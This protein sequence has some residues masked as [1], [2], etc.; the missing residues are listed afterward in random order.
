MGRTFEPRTFGAGNQRAT[1]APQVRKREPAGMLGPRFF[2]IIHQD[3]VQVNLAP[4]PEATRFCFS[5]LAWRSLFL[6]FT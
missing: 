1:T 2:Y 6:H 3:I 4:N 5:L